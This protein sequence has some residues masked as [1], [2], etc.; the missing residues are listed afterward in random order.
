MLRPFEQLP[1]RALSARPSRTHPYTELAPKTVTVRSSHFG[2]VGIHVREMGAG[3]P[4]LL[5]HGL[6]TTG[7]SWRF[8]L[9]ALARHRRV[10]VPDLVGCGRSDKP[11]TT[12]PPEAVG[13]FLGELQDALDLRGSDVVGNSLGGYLA[14]QLCLAS[15]WAVRRLVNI[16]S[17]GVPMARLYALRAAMGLPGAE[18]L[19]HGII[20]SFGPERWAHKNVHYFDEALKSREEAREYGQPL[21]T[22]EGRRAFSR[23]LR[24][25]LSPLAMRRFVG[26]LK[27]APFPVPLLLLYAERDPMVPPAV[28]ERLAALVPNAELAWLSDCSHFA[29][30]DRPEAVAEAI[31]AFLR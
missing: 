14:M 5:V 8:V 1:F 29:Q 12:Y 4:L 21:E 23:Y 20:R 27:A 17:P 9:S 18:R 22:H 26:R 30:V 11:D 24:D 25:T 3:E 7:Y 10:V 16:H 31:L 2:A 19:L 13:R 15:P 6:M 28:G